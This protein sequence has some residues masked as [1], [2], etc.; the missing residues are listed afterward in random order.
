ME[1]DDSYN[2]QSDDSE[3]LIDEENP[4]G[5]SNN[6]NTTDGT[7]LNKKS[8]KSQKKSKTSQKCP[9]NFHNDWSSSVYTNVVSSE[10]TGAG[11]R[12]REDIEFLI[13]LEESEIESRRATHHNYLEGNSFQRMVRDVPPQ[14]LQPILN[15]ITKVK[16]LQASQSQTPLSSAR[17]KLQKPSWK[18]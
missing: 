17:M 16:M 12:S 15:T 14:A 4:A 6:E 5:N 10:E 7:N 11:E 1:S 13:S 2:R 8:Q 3:E 18:Q 9:K